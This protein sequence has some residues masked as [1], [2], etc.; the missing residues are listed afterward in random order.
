[1][2]GFFW[3]AILPL[4]VIANFLDAHERGVTLPWKLLPMGIGMLLFGIAIVEVSRRWFNF[5]LG[6]D[7]CT[8]RKQK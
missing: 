5:M 1:M 8:W 3:V 7:V 6:S 4:I 2:F